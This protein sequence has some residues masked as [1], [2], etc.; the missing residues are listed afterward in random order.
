ML[1]ETAD[2][3]HHTNVTQNLFQGPRETQGAGE[4]LFALY[5]SGD[6]CVYIYISKQYMSAEVSQEHV[7]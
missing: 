3:L 2:I 5:M 6:S 7:N 4:G 1:A